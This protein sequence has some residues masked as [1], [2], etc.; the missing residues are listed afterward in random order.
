MCNLL[1]CSLPLSALLVSGTT[2]LLFSIQGDDLYHRYIV[3]DRHVPFLSRLYEYTFVCIGA[4]AVVNIFI[5]IIQDSYTKSALLME[6][7]RTVREE[8]ITRC[9][10]EPLS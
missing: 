8:L 9:M 5:A 4:Y 7:R 2:W 6:R 1:C 3:L 10:N